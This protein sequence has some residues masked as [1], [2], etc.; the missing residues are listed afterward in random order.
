MQTTENANNLG[1]KIANLQTYTKQN[2]IKFPMLAGCMNLAVHN[3]HSTNITRV[4]FPQINSSTGPMTS[5]LCV[6]GNDTTTFVGIDT[7]TERV[8]SISTKVPS[9]LTHLYK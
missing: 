9:E 1:S 6:P 8:A 7:T 4:H 5:T 2:G 3:T